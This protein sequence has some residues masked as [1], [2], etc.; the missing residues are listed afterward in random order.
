MATLR[1]A[2]NSFPKSALD[3]IEKNIKSISGIDKELFDID[4][5]NK[6]VKVS[7]CSDAMY[8]AIEELV[9]AIGY[10]CQRQQ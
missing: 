10:S 1:G 9:I 2:R 8:I 5:T 6:I 7:N 4:E 3:L